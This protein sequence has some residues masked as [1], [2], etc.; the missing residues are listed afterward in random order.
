MKKKEKTNTKSVLY[1]TKTS[2]CNHKENW[3]TSMQF[4]ARQLHTVP[5][6]S[7]KELICN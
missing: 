3:I 6:P 2:I 7:E 4:E 1:H 5:Q